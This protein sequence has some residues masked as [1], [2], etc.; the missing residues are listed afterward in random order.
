M[1]VYEIY[2]CIQV[3]KDGQGAIMG[4]FKVLFRCLPGGSAGKTSLRILHVQDDIQ[5]R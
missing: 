2:S 4:K 3:E 5:I 1:A